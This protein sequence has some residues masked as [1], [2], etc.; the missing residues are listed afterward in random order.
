MKPDGPGAAVVTAFLGRTEKGGERMDRRDAAVG[1]GLG[2]DSL[3]AA[4][5]SAM[6]EDE[7]GTDPFSAGG[8]LPETIG[9]IV[10]STRPSGPHD[11]LLEARPPLTADQRAVVTPRAA[12]RTASCSPSPAGG[13]GAAAPR[14][15]AL[16]HRRARR[17]MG[18]AAAGRRRP[19]RR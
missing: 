7:F 16:R 6:L 10:P 13:I 19:G 12:L 8:D 18:A 17:G 5:L 9:D 3:E 14:H 2:L 15:H 4:E 1:E 11:R